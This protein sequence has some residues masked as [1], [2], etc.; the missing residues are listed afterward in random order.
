MVV[1]AENLELAAANAGGFNTS[2]NI[3]DLAGPGSSRVDDNVVLV[4]QPNLN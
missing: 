2:I 3:N 4:N 1:K